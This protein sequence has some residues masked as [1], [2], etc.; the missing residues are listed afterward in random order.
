[1]NTNRIRI[2]R[3]GKYYVLI[4]RYHDVMIDGVLWKAKEKWK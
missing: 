4:P 2:I 3:L 1:M